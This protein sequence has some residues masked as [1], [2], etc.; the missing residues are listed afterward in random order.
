MYIHKYVNFRYIIIF[1]IML[2]LLQ[3]TIESIDFYV[4][5]KI[6]P[7]KIVGICLN[8][9]RHSYIPLILVYPS[10]LYNPH[11][12]LTRTTSQ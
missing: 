7:E 6:F 1:V 9:I 12:P 5:A 4:F 2:I 11:T 10:S 3:T 8:I